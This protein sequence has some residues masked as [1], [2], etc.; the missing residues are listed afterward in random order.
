MTRRRQIHEPGHLRKLLVVVDDSPECD[1]AVYYAARRAARTAGGL[2]LL[3]VLTLADVESQWFGVA[4]LM[5][6]EAADKATARLEHMAARA[7]SV[8]GVTA[9]TLIREG[10]VVDEI[11]KLIEADEDIALLVVAV[12]AGREA[13][14][15]LI[16][17]LGSGLWAGLGIPITLVPGT[18]S[19]A[20][21]D[22]LA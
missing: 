22:A 4:E 17:S 19:D 13:P 12:H 21:I 1:R 9:Q 15:S 6:A 20:E 11:L 10:A 7:R 3:R 18:L 8:A 5:R 14:A 2:V 16:S